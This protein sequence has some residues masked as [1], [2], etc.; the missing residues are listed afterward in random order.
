MDPICAG[1]G[2][3]EQVHG[4]PHTLCSWF[5]ITLF[6]SCFWRGGWSDPKHR[7]CHGPSEEQALP[8]GLGGSSSRESRGEAPATTH[9]S[10]SRRCAQA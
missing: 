4:E 3:S 2:F 1:K 6:P 7:G 8:P 10:S 9:C 5:I